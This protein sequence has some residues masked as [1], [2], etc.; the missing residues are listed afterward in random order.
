MGENDTVEEFTV[1]TWVNPDAVVTATCVMC[2]T[3]ARFESGHDYSIG[4]TF[5]Q[6]CYSCGSG[7][8]PGLGSTTLYRVTESNP[9]LDTPPV[10]ATPPPVYSS[11]DAD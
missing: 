10:A 3:Q 4:D 9:D 5:R 11:E 1:D 6:Q 2:G 7:Q 8:F